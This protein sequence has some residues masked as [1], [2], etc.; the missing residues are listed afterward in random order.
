MGY[1]S[2][3]ATLFFKGTVEALQFFNRKVYLTVREQAFN[4]ECRIHFI[5][6]ATEDNSLVKS[7]LS[8]HRIQ[9]HKNGKDASFA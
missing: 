4:L 2:F 1:A 3:L 9:E 5:L 7:S 8:S 6:S